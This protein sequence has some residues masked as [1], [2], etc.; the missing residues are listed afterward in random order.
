MLFARNPAKGGT[1]GPQA[2]FGAEKG[3]FKVKVGKEKSAGPRKKGPPK[4]RAA[5][6]V[7]TWERVF[8][9]IR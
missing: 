8:D 1:S 7:L 5:S 2:W 4:G 9:M 6:K 3:L